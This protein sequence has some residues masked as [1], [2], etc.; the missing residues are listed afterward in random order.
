M[1]VQSSSDRGL[2]FHGGILT[3]DGEDL[4]EMLAH[5]RHG[6][7]GEINFYGTIKKAGTYDVKVGQLSN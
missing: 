1:R 3:A 7:P 6:G 4:G 5:K 2:P